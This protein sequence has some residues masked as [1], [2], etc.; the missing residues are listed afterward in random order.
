MVGDRAGDLDQQPPGLSKLHVFAIVARRA[1]PHLIEATIIPAVLFYVCL[2]MAGVG[3]AFVSAL[4]WS[5]GALGRRLLRH[6]PVPPL[7][8]IGVIGITTRTLIS[9]L[10]GSSFF[11][12]FQPIL[13]TFAMAGVFLISVIVGRPLIGRLAGEFWPITPEIAAR[14][15]ILRLFRRLTLL[16]AGV[17]LATAALTMVLLLWLPL[18]TFLALKQLSGLAITGGGVF[19]T[20]SLSLRTARREGVASAPMWLSLSDHPVGRRRASPPRDWAPIRL[21]VD[22]GH[23]PSPAFLSE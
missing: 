15:A 8:V 5:Y 19:L 20:I 1:G 12:F 13:G 16:W 23:F 6:R 7:L 17:N 21:V 9:V 2:V 11:Y 18:A 4:A 14:P 3:P 22:A 10:S